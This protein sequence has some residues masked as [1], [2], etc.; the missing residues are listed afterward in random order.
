[1]EDSVRIKSYN[2]DDPEFC[3]SLNGFTK[4]EHI[5]KDF[6]DIFSGGFEGRKKGDSITFRFTGTGI[7]AQYKRTIIQP[8]P[9]ATAV[10]DDDMEHPIILD[11]NFDETWGDCLYMDVLGRHLELKEHKVVITITETHDDDK[12]PFYL[13][14]LIV[15]K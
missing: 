13:T 11:G 9:I 2:M 12:G 10:V 5:K 6:L 7:A 1:Y 15:S 4:D 14:S 3:V 8:A